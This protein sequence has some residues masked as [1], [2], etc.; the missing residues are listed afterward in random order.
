MKVLFDINV[1]LDVLLNRK[2]FV[3]EAVLLFEFVESGKII[4]YISATAVTTLNYLLSR[5]TTAREADTGVKKLLQLFEIAPITRLVL[6][7]ALQKN[8]ADFE[9]AVMDSAASHCGV[10]AIVTRDEKGFSKSRLAIYSPKALL[11]A[12]P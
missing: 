2:P 5:A 11:C 1:I 6:E 10:Q 12:L 9:D 4:G 7:D 3:D 8:F